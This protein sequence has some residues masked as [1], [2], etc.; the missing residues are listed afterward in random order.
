MKLNSTE[1]NPT[2]VS[3]GLLLLLVFAGFSMMTHGYPKLQKLLA[4]G[5]ADFMSFMGLSP[6]ISLALAVFAEFVCSIL[7]VLGLFTR[8]AVVPLL[9][10]MLTAATFVHSGDLYSKKELALAYFFIYVMLLIAGSGRFS[11][12][13]MTERRRSDW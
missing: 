2:F 7:I 13:A 3:I 8:V 1:I 12:D 9:I 5:E 10:T 6:D 4:D 11:V